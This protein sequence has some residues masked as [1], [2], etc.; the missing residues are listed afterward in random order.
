MLTT[1]WRNGFIMIKATFE[2]SLERYAE[3]EEEKE[4]SIG[5]V[6]IKFIGC[7]PSSGHCCRY[8]MCTD[9]FTSH[10]NPR[11]WIPLLSPF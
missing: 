2:L 6:M 5:C 11:R 4:A 3:E 10:R 8:S 1:G 7:L 9:S